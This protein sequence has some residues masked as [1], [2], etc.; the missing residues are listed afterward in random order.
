MRIDDRE[1]LVLRE[2]ARRCF[3]ICRCC[4]DGSIFAPSVGCHLLRAVIAL[5]RNRG[6]RAINVVPSLLDRPRDMPRFKA[7]FHKTGLAPVVVR[8]IRPTVLSSEARANESRHH[9]PAR[10]PGRRVAARALAHG[11]LQRAGGGREAL[12]ECLRPNRRAA[13]TPLRAD[14]E[15]SRSRQGLHGPREGDARRRDQGPQ[16]RDGGRTESRR[17]PQRHGGDTGV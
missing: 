2:T 11:H 9:R 8:W 14:S 15:P 7:G 5:E 12:R 17:Q 1:S 6:R 3:L 13:Q 4:R 10:A 16:Q